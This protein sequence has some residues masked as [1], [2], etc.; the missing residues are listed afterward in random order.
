MQFVAHTAFKP[1]AA[2]WTGLAAM[3][4]PAS[5][6]DVG[7]PRSGGASSKAPLVVSRRRPSRVTANE[8]ASP[9][10]AGGSTG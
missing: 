10:V 8:L 5:C 7:G 6:A 4:L 1:E 2:V 9:R 3:L